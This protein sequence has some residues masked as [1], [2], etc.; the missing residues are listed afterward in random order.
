M[1]GIVGINASTPMLTELL[2]RLKRLEYRGYDSSG[3]AMIRNESLIVIKAKGKLDNLQMDINLDTH[4]APCGIAHMRWATHG[5]PSKRNAH[6]QSYHDVAIVHNGIIENHAILRKTLETEGHHF[7]SDTDSEIIAHLI[8][9]EM[10]SGFTLVEAVVRITHHLEGSFAFAA[11]C[12][13]Y[14]DMIVAAVRKSPM[15]IGKSKHCCYVASD[16]LAIADG[17]EHLLHLSDDEIAVLHQGHVEIL[18]NQ[19]N[20]VSHLWEEITEHHA[21]VQLHDFP[22]YTAKEIAEQPETLK[23]TLVSLAKAPKTFLQTAINHVEIIACGSSYYAGLLGK[24][25][26]EKFAQLPVTVHIASEYR[27]HPPLHYPQ[28]L[29]L[30]ISQSGETADTIAAMQHAKEIG[31]PCLALTNAGHSFLSRNADEAWILKAGMEIGVAATKSFTAQVT[32]LAYLS[33]QLAGHKTH[34][35]SQTLLAEMR[36]LK[37]LPYLVKHTLELDAD[38]Y[39]LGE[40]LKDA[41]SLLMIGRGPSYVSALEGALKLKELSY[42]Q[43]EAYAAGELKHGPIAL[44]EP[45]MPVLVFAPGGH[46]FEKTMSNAQE[47]RARGASITLITDQLGKE[48]CDIIVDNL[49]LLPSCDPYHFALLS[50]I[51]CQMLAYHTAVCKGFDVDKPRNLAKSVTVE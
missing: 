49:F 24:C 11:V 17:A 45:A 46:L 20:A 38:I 5:A 51:W 41:G 37:N 18:D 48:K 26:I 13:R 30:F 33:I 21:E 6:P 28:S 36:R 19:G 39:Q 31:M 25:W 23:R 16:S 9:K 1:C 3:I 22:H 12:P 34:I 44:I 43:A 2:R 15:V 50:T 14:P 4:D 7:T 32:A 27:Y 42:I 29:A 47:V 8:Y 10:D 40:S 35:A